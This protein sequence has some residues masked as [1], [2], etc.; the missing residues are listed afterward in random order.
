[1]EKYL[2]NFSQ[3]TKAVITLQVW[4]YCK[5]F[6]CKG[7]SAYQRGSWSPFCGRVCVG[8]FD[9]AMSW[10]TGLNVYTLEMWYTI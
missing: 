10:G 9:R 3:S 8:P 5:M 4:H 1:M 2:R 7:T 6:D